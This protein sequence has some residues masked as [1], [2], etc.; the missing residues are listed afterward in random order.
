MFKQDSGPP[1]AVRQ[2]ASSSIMHRNMTW[3]EAEDV[4]VASRG[5][6]GT[7]D[8]R[9]PGLLGSLSERRDAWR[10]AAKLLISQDWFDHA[11]VALI[12]VNCVFLALDDPTAEASIA[13]H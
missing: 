3:Q 1:P 7:C 2:D 13:T 9:C 12:L 5:F 10:L 6:T 11:V 8:E 4:P